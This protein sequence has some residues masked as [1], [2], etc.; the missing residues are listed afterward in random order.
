MHTFTC[1]QCYQWS[2]IPKPK[3]QRHVGVYVR[4][5]S[6]IWHVSNHQWQIHPNPICN[7][8]NG[9]VSLNP[10]H[11]RHLG[12]YVSIMPDVWQVIRHKWPILSILGTLDWGKAFAKSQ[13]GGANPVVHMSY[14]WM[15]L[16]NTW[17]GSQKHS[18]ECLKSSIHCDIL[19]INE[20]A[21]NLDVSYVIN[22][23]NSMSL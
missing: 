9:R 15:M 13:G 14:M 2:W 22:G 11:Q 12:Q 23:Y 17:L 21:I 18:G 16:I 6:H 7:V 1:M 5:Y 3:K 20:C 8:I 10:G 19:H 4:K